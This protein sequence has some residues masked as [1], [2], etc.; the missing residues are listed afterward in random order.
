MCSPPRR[1]NAWSGSDAR[2]RDAAVP[3]SWGAA[4]R[5][6][7]RDDHL[8]NHAFLMDR[9]GSWTL[10]PAYDLSFSAGPGGEHTLLVAGEGRRPG[11]AHIGQV[12]A[13]AGI[14]PSR[15]AEIVGEVDAAVADWT[16]FARVAEVPESM[17]RTIK[18]AMAAPPSWT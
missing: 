6:L 7:N 14:R 5:A 17:P 2:S 9:T 10:A 15:A 13:K 8:K 16:N 18:A 3:H 12:A 11:R 1:Q 4:I